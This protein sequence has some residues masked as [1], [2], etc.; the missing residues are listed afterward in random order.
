MEETEVL[1]MIALENNP[2]NKAILLTFYAGGFRVSEVA[3]LKWK[4]LQSRDEAGQITVFAKGGKTNSVLMPAAVWVQLVVLR[5]DDSGESPV[6][7]SRKKGHLSECQIWRIV[8][9]AAERAGIEKAVSCHW[10]RHAHASHSLEVDPS[11][12]TTG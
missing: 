6:F 5:G 11:F 7:R 1:R 4:H 9:K 2:R 3:A 8:R 12:R 10:L